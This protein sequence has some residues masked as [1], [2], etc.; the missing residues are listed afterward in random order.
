M[1]NVAKAQIVFVFFL[2]RRIKLTAIFYYHFLCIPVRFS[3]WINKTE[4]I[5]IGFF[6][7]FLGSHIR[8][9]EDY[10]CSFSCSSSAET[11]RAS[12]NS[13]TATSLH[14]LLT[15]RLSLLASSLLKQHQLL[16][17]C[18]AICFQLV[19]VDSVR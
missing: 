10:S 9:Y 15:S 12:I 16:Y 13:A 8:F 3:K 17:R 5:R 2:V 7:E 4:Q 11:L 1:I 18:K 14:K 6:E 19:E